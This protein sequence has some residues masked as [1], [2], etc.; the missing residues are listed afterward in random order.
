MAAVK[1]KKK[2]LSDFFYMR[3]GSSGSSCISLSCKPHQHS[4]CSPL[5]P[6]SL[7]DCHR[8]MELEWGHQWEVVRGPNLSVTLPICD[9]RGEKWAYVTVQ[10]SSVILHM[11]EP[12]HQARETR[13]VCVSSFSST[14]PVADPLKQDQFLKVADMKQ[15]N[16][17]S[18]EQKGEK[19][20]PDMITSFRVHVLLFRWQ[21]G[22][23]DLPHLCWH[24][25]KSKRTLPFC[26]IPAI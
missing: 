22:T 12:R 13:C 26:K 11:L 3:S 16:L 15:N 5:P 25:S 21:N 4:F 2:L 6:H 7:T 9:N 20:D 10:I 18:N 17:F 14:F 19:S 23:R 1:Y 8:V 24:A